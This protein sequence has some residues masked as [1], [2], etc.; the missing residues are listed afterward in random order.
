MYIYMA[1][2]NESGNPQQAPDLL[3]Y[4]L[5]LVIAPGD[6]TLPQLPLLGVHPHV[7]PVLHQLG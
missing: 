1:K 6:T 4:W 2:E 7:S 5:E 3:Q